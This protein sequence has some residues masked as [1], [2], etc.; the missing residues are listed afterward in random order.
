ME[1]IKN[2]MSEMMKS[3]SQ[4]MC[5]FESGLQK[6]TSPSTIS[7]LAAEYAD[8]KSFITGALQSL[9]L[10]IQFMAKELD[11]L[12]MRGR[13]KILLVHG[14]AEQPKEDLN[15]VVVRL[16]TERLRQGSF[17]ASDISRCHRMG[18]MTNDNRPRPILFKLRDASVRSKVW[19]AKTCLKGS[20]I[21]MSE[22]LTKT[23]HDAF[24]AARER[25]GI[26][27]CW[28][29]EGTVYVLGADGARHRV[30]CVDDLASVEVV[31]AQEEIPR[32]AATAKETAK[33]RRVA[34][35]RR[36]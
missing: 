31:A 5:Q 25:F 13:R 11:H 32:P 1:D 30:R 34:A 27:K 8:F 28:T 10:Q 2:S 33:P 16:V 29:M 17:S 23:R 14:V 9:Q 20:G 19:S 6:S 18:R 12:E 7:G 22:F 21:T 35:T 26:A 3:F 15:Q 4:R 36:V 24:M